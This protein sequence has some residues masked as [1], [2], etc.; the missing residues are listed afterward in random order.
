MRQKPSNEPDEAKCDMNSSSPDG[1][2]RMRVAV[3][4]AGPSGLTTIKQLKE[5]GME[6]ICLEKEQHIGGVFYWAPHKNGVYDNTTLTISNA[7][8]SFSDYTEKQRFFMHHSQYLD[9]LRGYAEHYKLLD[10]ICFGAT[11]T[12][13]SPQ[14]GMWI[15]EWK[16]KD[17]VQK[18]WFDAVAICTGTHQKPR[19]PQIQGLQTFPSVLHTVWYKNNM[20]FKDKKVLCIGLGESGAD[21]VREVSDVAEECV[22]GLRSLP[23]CLDRLQ[24]NVHATDSFST[25]SHHA[26]A[27]VFSFNARSM[28]GFESFFIRI[29]LVMLSLA[30]TVFS[31]ARWP[32]MNLPLPSNGKDEFG[33]PLTRMKMRDLNTVRKK[34]A[35]ILL[36]SWRYFGGNNILNPHKFLTKNSTFVNNVLDGKIKVNASGIKAVKGGLVTF[37]NGEAY[38]PDIILC[39]TGYVDSFEFLDGVEVPGNDVRNLFKHAFHA[40]HEGRL[41]FIGWARPVSGGIPCCS[42]MVARYFASLLCGRCHLP[43]DLQAIILKEKELEEHAVSSSPELRAVVPSVVGFLDGIAKEIGC[44]F[45]AVEYWHSPLLLWKVWAGGLVASQYRLR[46]PHAA[47]KQAKEAIMSK[48]VSMPSLYVLAFSWDYLVKGFCPSCAALSV[49]IDTMQHAFVANEKYLFGYSR[50]ESKV[51]KQKMLT[52]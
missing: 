23:C 11:V 48:K 52:L 34:E 20:T 7:L 50:P 14:E 16:I 29:Y 6:P 19:Y 33:Q 47:S 42:E 35:D 45:R 38:S 27:P 44:E 10:H 30:M 41:A 36:T 12:R 21:I 22:L 3:I 9:Y 49:R 15:V 37:N 31:I 24:D 5:E 26:I 4:G 28:L 8:M 17:D 40:Q 25:R 39:C 51:L 43:S 13:V 2:K 32:F 18:Q 46:G 1:E